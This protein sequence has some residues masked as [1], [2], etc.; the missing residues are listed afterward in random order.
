M[1]ILIFLTIIANF[2]ILN[3]SKVYSRCGLATELYNVHGIPF[4]QV[5]VFVCI[6][7]W[8][9]GYS[10]TMHNGRANGIFGIYDNVW[11]SIDTYGYGCQLICNDLRDDSISDDITC[12][13]HIFRHHQKKEGNGFLA[14]SYYTS[15]CKDR[16]VTGAYI[17][18]CF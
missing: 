18:G 11:C 13:R 14:W 2:F 3:E 9:S 7:K 6:A 17:D 8:S 15:H 5:E 10:T 12:A 1:L 4:D 16:S